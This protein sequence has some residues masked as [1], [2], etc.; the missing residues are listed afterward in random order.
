MRYLTILIL[1]RRYN[2]SPLD[3]PGIKAKIMTPSY[4]HDQNTLT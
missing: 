2:E 1:M 3:L 4:G